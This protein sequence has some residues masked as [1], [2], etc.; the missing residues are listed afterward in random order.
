M[1]GGEPEGRGVLYGYNLSLL[2]STER[3]IDTNNLPGLMR[4]Y[5]LEM[6]KVGNLDE[7]E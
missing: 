2:V 7:K 5:N 3:N 4:R 1:G 6:R